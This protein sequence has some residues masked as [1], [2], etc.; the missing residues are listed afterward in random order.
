MKREDKY[1][2]VNTAET[3]TTTV[4]K[5]NTFLIQQWLSVNDNNGVLNNCDEGQKRSKYVQKGTYALCTFLIC[6]ATFHK[7]LGLCKIW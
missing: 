3:S 6:N 1:C 7:K 4:S 5:M 2:S